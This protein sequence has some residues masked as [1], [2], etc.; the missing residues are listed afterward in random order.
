[1]YIRPKNF[2]SQTFFW[3]LVQV[4]DD[5]EVQN[6]VKVSTDLPTLTGRFTKTR[7][8]HCL[9]IS[10]GIF[11]LLHFFRVMI[12][13]KKKKKV[14]SSRVC[15]I[16]FPRCLPFASMIILSSIYN[17]FLFPLLFVPFIRTFSIADIKR[18][19]C[20]KWPSHEYLNYVHLHSQDIEI[21]LL[22]YGSSIT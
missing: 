9:T 10:K 18:T 22:S 15:G 2:Q 21:A 16:L 5:L 4:G 14:F 3:W 8:A 17:S 20:Y 1:M 11:D 12:E 7:I 19:F 13:K 6:L